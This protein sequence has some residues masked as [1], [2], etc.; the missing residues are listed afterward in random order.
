M[1]AFSPPKKSLVFIHGSGGDHKLWSKQWDLSDE[2]MEIIIPDLPGHGLSEDKGRERIA[3]YA[4]WLRGF[5]ERLTCE[6]AI[7]VGHSM[8]GQLLRSSPSVILTV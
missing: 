2:E 1:R 7:L 3:D 8:G 5:L 4:E 6:Y